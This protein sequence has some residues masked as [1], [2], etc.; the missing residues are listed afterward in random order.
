MF[1]TTADSALLPALYSALKRFCSR[2][3]VLCSSVDVRL[4]A[5]DDCVVTNR[6]APYSQFAYYTTLYA[7]LL[8]N[9]HT[10]CICICIYIYLVPYHTLKNWCSASLLNLLPLL[11]IST[12]SLPLTLTLPLTLPLFYTQRAGG[13]SWTVDS[14]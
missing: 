4:N 5:C 10:I 14:H 11:R 9:T 12:S 1:C 2:C 7:T 13:S 8:Y 3:A 6:L